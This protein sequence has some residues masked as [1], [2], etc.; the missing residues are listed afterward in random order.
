MMSLMQEQQL[1]MSHKTLLGLALCLAMNT[2]IIARHKMFT[3]EDIDGAGTTMTS[4]QTLSNCCKQCY[5]IPCGTSGLGSAGVLGFKCFACKLS[6]IALDIVC[7][8][9][10]WTSLILE[11][12]YVHWVPVQALIFDLTLYLTA[13]MVCVYIVAIV[14]HM[15]GGNDL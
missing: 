4:M 7:F 3:P 1:N 5:K 8:V 14:C 12:G 15:A 2:G 10:P 11:R 6:V 9:C 13:A